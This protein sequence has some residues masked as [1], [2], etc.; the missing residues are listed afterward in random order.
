MEIKYRRNID[1]LLHHHNVFGAVAEIGV[2]EGLNSR[3]MMV[4]W[5]VPKLYL[6]DMWQHRPNIS[7]DGNSAQEW[8]DSNL[9]NVKE[10]LKDYSDR[11]VF[12]QGDSVAMADHVPDGSL[13]LVYID[14]DHTYDGCMRDIIAWFPKLVPNGI[15]AFHDYLN[16]DYGVNAAVKQFASANNLE[17]HEIPEDFADNAGA[18]FQNKK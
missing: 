17:V 1:Q 16:N 9:N 11:T 15:M 3:D 6:V 2:A 12:L 13:G 14:A 10:L 4:H 8:H 5:D 7:G 18:W